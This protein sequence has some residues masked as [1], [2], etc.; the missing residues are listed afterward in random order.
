MSLP[1]LAQGHLAMPI[2]SGRKGNYQYSNGMPRYYQ[3]YLDEFSS[4]CALP[5]PP[6][7][8]KVD[9]NAY[10][11]NF[12]QLDVTTCDHPQEDEISCR[13]SRLLKSHEADLEACLADSD[14]KSRDHELEVEASHRG[15]CTTLMIRHIACKYTQEEVMG[16][17]DEAGFK[18]T[19][20]FLYLPVNMD[21]RK[22]T[23][24]GYLFVNFIELKAAEACMQQLTGQIFGN[25]PTEKRCEVV[26]AHIQGAAAL[27]WP[28]RSPSILQVLM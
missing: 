18:G 21:Q 13:L 3:Q 22:K 2:M 6:G 26:P 15:G 10:D 8:H 1:E 23:N 17:L 9:C 25:G 28:T 16:F 5:L 19:Y 27:L 7:L 14:F 11:F 12:E 20:D 4:P 24:V